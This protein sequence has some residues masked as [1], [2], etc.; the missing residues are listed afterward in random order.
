MRRLLLD[1]DPYGGTDKLGMF[2]LFLKRTSDL[3]AS[4]LSVV[5]RRLVLLGRSA[6]KTVQKARVVQIDF[7]AAF[8]RVNHLEILYKLCSV[9]IGGSVFSILTQFLSNRQSTLWWM[10]VGVNLVTLY[11]DCRRAMFLARYC[12]SCSF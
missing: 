10:I 9:C 2:H 7:T 12:S 3:M 1:L 8:D 5:F 4:R 11:Q 6:M